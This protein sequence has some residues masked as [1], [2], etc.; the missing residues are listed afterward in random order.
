MYFFITFYSVFQIS[1][2]SEIINAYKNYN[3]IRLHI[4]ANSNS[5]E[6]Q[7]IKRKLRN[8]IKEEL[9]HISRE[10]YNKEEKLDKVEKIMDNFLEENEMNYSGR[11]SFGKE[12]FPRR[13]Y[14]NMTLPAGEYQAVRIVLGE[15]EGANWW[16]VLFPPLCIQSE[17]NQDQVTN[18]E[19]SNQ[20]HKNEELNIQFRFKLADYFNFERFDNIKHFQAELSNINNLTKPEIED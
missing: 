11:V 17:E 3:L 1:N 9:Q 12:E 10:N 4:V 14:G 5:P 19:Q 16:C 13:T 8:T 15:G 7:Y 20:N 6:D 2:S 18:I